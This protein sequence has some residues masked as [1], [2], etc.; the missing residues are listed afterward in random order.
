MTGD[1]D[2]PGGEIE[3]V[4]SFPLE[5]AQNDLALAFSQDAT[6]GCASRHRNI[7]IDSAA[8]ALHC[9]E[10]KAEID[11]FEMVQRMVNERNGPSASLNMLR[12]Q[13]RDAERN[14]AALKT[15]LRDTRAAIRAEVDRDP[16][17]VYRLGVLH[18]VGTWIDRAI[19]TEAQ[20]ELYLPE[21]RA[22]RLIVTAMF[23]SVSD[24]TQAAGGN[25]RFRRKLN[26]AIDE[27]EARTRRRKLQV[28]QPS[29][30]RQAANK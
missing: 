6:Q 2:K 19:E 29:G 1:G 21:L 26:A 4:I 12:S 10:C 14:L 3:N 7:A 17:E 25:E 13:C 15:E 20:P 18:K 27:L 16:V 28:I 23:G 22:C 24:T 8:R 30:K 11:P 5:F 9:R